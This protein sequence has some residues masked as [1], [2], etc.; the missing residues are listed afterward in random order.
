MSEHI[1]ESPAARGL[2]K[3]LSEG[4]PEEVPE[5]FATGFRNFHA[6]CCG[7]VATRPDGSEWPFMMTLHDGSTT[8]GVS[9]AVLLS[10]MIAGYAEAGEGERAALRTR[11]ALTH[12]ARAQD[13]AIAR[14]REAGTV[15]PGDPAD[16]PLLDLLALPK[17]EPLHL[18]LGTGDAGDAHA[19]QAPWLAAVPLVLVTTSYAP[20]TGT[21]PVTGNVLWIDPAGE[22]A[23]LGSLRDA[24]LYDIWMES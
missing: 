7:F 16:G 2:S 13:L 4:M 18:A 9:A 21:A 22:V 19:E 11:D 24:G 3:E 14:A 1:G 17:N 12:A 6:G 23:Y 15:D 10:E 5:A 8:H 20:H